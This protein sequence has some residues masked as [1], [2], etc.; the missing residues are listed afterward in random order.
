[1][2]LIYEF[3]GNK[4]W[5]PAALATLLCYFIIFGIVSLIAYI[6]LISMNGAYNQDWWLFIFS[7]F[8]LSIIVSLLSII[9]F[10]N[11]HTKLYKKNNQ[12]FFDLDVNGLSHDKY[13]FIIDNIYKIKKSSPMNI[14]GKTDI[15]LYIDNYKMN[16][17]N[18]YKK[19]KICVALVCSFEEKRSILDIIKFNSKK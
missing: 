8:C 3:D 16:G 1:M 17:E 2:K 12:L 18:R 10:R 5:I 19:M 13:E 6:V 7:P 15:V 4:K 11:T 14:I 9:S